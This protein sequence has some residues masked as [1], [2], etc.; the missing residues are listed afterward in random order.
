MLS[1]QTSFEILMFLQQ[2]SVLIFAFWP[3]VDPAVSLKSFERAPF[4]SVLF[5]VE[6]PTFEILTPI[7]DDD[8]KGKK[9]CLE[10]LF[11]FVL[12]Q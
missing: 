8:K 4:V 10:I 11:C 2:R 1:A 12:L 9:L 6:H 5:L 7:S 3:H